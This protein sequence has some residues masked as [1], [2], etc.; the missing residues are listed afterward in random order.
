V[1]VQTSSKGPNRLFN[2]CVCETV[3]CLNVDVTVS[4]KGLTGKNDQ[5]GG[6]VW[7][8]QDENNYYIARLN[9]L[10]NNFRVYKVVNGRRIQLDSAHVEAT[11]SKWYTIRVV[12]TGN[13]MMCYLNGKKMLEATDT[14][15]TQPGHVGL[16]TKSD[17]VTEFDNFKVECK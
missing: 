14:S 15:I 16:W 1:L 7:R 5:G 9:P 4:L 17:A 2:L 10:E 8:Y 6:P 11:A 13:K 12:Q 3:T